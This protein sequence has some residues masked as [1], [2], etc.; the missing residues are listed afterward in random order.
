M[1]YSNNNIEFLVPDDVVGRAVFIH[2]LGPG[3]E[4]CI[5]HTCKNYLSFYRDNAGH[6]FGAPLIKW[7]VTL[8]IV[9][10]NG[11]KASAQH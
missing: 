1:C 2:T 7:L 10:A 11:E 5:R 4:S 8:A 9:V 3:I 6:L